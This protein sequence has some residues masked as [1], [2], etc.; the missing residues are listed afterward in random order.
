MTKTKQQ[1]A[2]LKWFDSHLE[3]TSTS[4]DVITKFLSYTHRTMNYVQSYTDEDGKFHKGGA[5][6]DTTKQ[7][8]YRTTDSKHTIITYAGFFDRVRDFL[9]KKKFK[10]VTYD[11]RKTFPKLNLSNEN[12]DILRNYQK[13][14]LL[15]GLAKKKSGCF[16]LPTRSARDSSESR[17]TL[18]KGLPSTA[19]TCSIKVV[20]PEPVCPC[21]QQFLRVSNEYSTRVRSLGRMT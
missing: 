4:L 21:T 18:T 6:Y 19:Q 2:F 16:S 12:F 13:A 1:T 7:E 20:L 3:I 14:P 17:L 11:Y 8:L 15:Q 10:V 9:K 5:E